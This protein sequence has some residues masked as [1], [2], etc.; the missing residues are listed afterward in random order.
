MAERINVFFNN[1]SAG[2]TSLAIQAGRK[3]CRRV[4]HIPVSE[5]A[6]YASA[7]GL[8]A[9]NYRAVDVAAGALDLVR[10]IVVCCIGRAG[11]VVAER[12]SVRK[13][14]IDILLNCTA[15]AA[16][17]IILRR[18]RTG[19]SRI[20]RLRGNGFQI[21]GV[22]AGCRDTCIH[23]CGCTTA[24]A[25]LMLQTGCTA[26]WFLIN[27]PFISMSS[28]F[29]FYVERAGST[30]IRHPCSK[31]ICF[32]GLQGIGNSEIVSAAAIA[33]CIQ[34]THAGIVKIAIGIIRAG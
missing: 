24:G 23:A 20:S 19:C 33:G 21:I 28:T 12:I 2:C 1:I 6:V 25:E 15:Y 4:Y 11:E 22:F 8:N 9:V 34:L 5:R 32:T 30:G 29:Q 7:F 31:E 18:F 13:E 3:T 10:T 26:G 17:I 27:H 14:M 16:G